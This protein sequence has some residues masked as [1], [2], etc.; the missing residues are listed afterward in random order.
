MDYSQKKRSK[1]DDF[2]PLQREQRRRDF[3]LELVTMI[4]KAQQD[5]VR[6]ARFNFAAALILGII[7]VIFSIMQLRLASRVEQQR[8]RQDPPPIFGTGTQH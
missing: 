8:P 6:A 4:Q 7:V 1:N 3:E 2:D 5:S